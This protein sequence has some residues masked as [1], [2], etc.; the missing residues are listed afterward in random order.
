MKD[1][2]SINP[3]VVGTPWAKQQTGIPNL[4]LLR[5]H[6]DGS[7]F[8]IGEKCEQCSTYAS[9]RKEVHVFRSPDFNCQCM[10]EKQIDGLRQKGIEV[11]WINGRPD[12]GT[13][14]LPPSSTQT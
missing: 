11:I 7:G 4:C 1:E 8:N 10:T 12:Q 3:G 9:G 5:G 14:R 6:T 2:S 13:V